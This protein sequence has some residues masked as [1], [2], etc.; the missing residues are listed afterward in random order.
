MRCLK[1]P[2]RG[3]IYASGAAVALVAPLT[4]SALALR[5]NFGPDFA[6]FG[7][8]WTGA[9]DDELDLTDGLPDVF[10]L[11]PGG[12]QFNLGSTNPSDRVTFAS[13]PFLNGINIAGA[14]YTSFCLSKNGVIGFGSA[15]APC[16]LVPET[17]PLFSV[18]GGP[19]GEWNYLF[20]SPATAQSSISVS[21][22]LVDRVWEDVVDPPNLADARPALRFFWYGMVEGTPA[23]GAE[24]DLE[25]QAIFFDLGG[26]AFD[27]EFNYRSLYSNGIQRITTPDGSGGFNTLFAGIDDTRQGGSGTDP[28]FSFNSDGDFSVVTPTDPPTPVPE[29]STFWLLG[30]GGL[31]LFLRRRR[32]VA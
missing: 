17:S 7:E 27:V 21:L 16:T 23:S 5:I 22:G 26:G 12:S 2:L 8:D 29:P 24:D 31:A 28:Y 25:F 11:A 10:D 18:L 9:F 3:L 30:A 1:H 14:N 15:T 4:A 13:T 6:T 19:A 20:G 32:G